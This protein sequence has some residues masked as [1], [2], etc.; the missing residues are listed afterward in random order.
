MS[1]IAA[2]RRR[3]PKVRFVNGAVERTPK[4]VPFA[5]LNQPSLRRRPTSHCNESAELC[6]GVLQAAAMTEPSPA[7]AYNQPH[8][9]TAG[10]FAET[11]VVNHITTQTGGNKNE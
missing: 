8:I 4:T 7:K 3:A 11:P 2:Q 1:K 5:I 10:L 6:K 9:E